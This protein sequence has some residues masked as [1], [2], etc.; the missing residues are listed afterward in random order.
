M[1]NKEQ[2][3]R[4]IRVLVVDD[5]ALARKILTTGL[6]ADRRLEVIGAAPNP[7]IAFELLAKLHP[8]VLTL[9]IEM[10]GMDGVTFLKKFMPVYPT[11]TVVV[12]SLAE[13]GK[14][15]ALDALEAGAVD[16]V[17]KPKVG[18]ADGLPLLMGDICDR[19]TAAAKTDVSYYRRRLPEQAASL[20]EG[21]TPPGKKAA[22]AAVPITSSEALHETTDRVIA[23]G[24]SAGGVATL[25]HILPMFP[26]DAPG[27]VIVQHMPGGFTTS[28]AA[29]LNSLA[30]MQVKEAAHG[31][32]V[33]SGLVLLAPGGEQHMEVRRSGGEYRVVLFN[34]EKVS[35][36]RPSVN[37]LFRSVARQVGRNAAAALLTGMGDDGADG[38][39]AIRQ[40]GG[41]TMAQDEQTSVVFGM[42]AAAWERGAA[43]V[44]LPINDIPARLLRAAVS[45][46]EARNL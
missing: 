37:V 41:R 36:H 12:S 22:L 2:G 5:S 1:L 26:A 28:F 35:G 27:I 30:A 40:A 23:I 7:A 9:D 20:K 8:D 25:A 34:G 32:R 11:P 10:P 39:L 29:R 24:A 21:T 33:R 31:D 19:V 45:Q 43:E 44:Q 18:V 3:T 4:K 38:L 46:P 17:T 6:T 15:L 16:I 13:R 42:P 14:K